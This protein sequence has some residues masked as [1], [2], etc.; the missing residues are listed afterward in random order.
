MPTIITLTT[1]SGRDSAYA[2]AMKGVILSINPAAVIVD[3]SHGIGPQNI[4]EGAFVLGEASRWFPPGSI[5][6]AVVDP[7]VGTD[8]RI[9]Y[10]WV[11]GQQYVLPDNGL[12]SYVC[13]EQAPEA[14]FEVTNRSLFLPEVWNTFHGRDIM[15]PVAARLSLGLPPRELGPAINDLNLFEWPRP[16]RRDATVIGRILF[17]DSFGNLITSIRREDLPSDI[18]PASFAVEAAQHLLAGIVRTYGESAPGTLIALFSSSGLLEL[19][20]VQGNAAAQLKVAIGEEVGVRWK[21]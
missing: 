13:R 9:V 12:V 8:R 18:D 21:D 20:I 17:A 10:A 16:E 5:H 1:D 7:G 11:G 4:I 14:V 2:A 6:V 19:A 15:A 3:I